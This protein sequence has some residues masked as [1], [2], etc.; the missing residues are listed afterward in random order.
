TLPQF[1]EWLN[2]QAGK[3]PDESQT[4][5]L[6]FQSKISGYLKEQIIYGIEFLLIE[7]LQEQIIPERVAWLLNA[8]GSAWA[9]CHKEFVSALKNDLTIIAKVG[10]LPKSQH[11]EYFNLL[12][13][14]N[15]IWDRLINGWLNVN[16]GGNLTD[17]YPLAKLF[18]ST[19]DYKLAA[20]F[21]QLS[22]ASVPKDVFSKL[23]SDVALN[24]FKGQYLGLNLKS[25]KNTFDKIE[26]FANDNFIPIAIGI[27]LSFTAGILSLVWISFITK[28]HITD[29]KNI[30]LKSQPNPNKDEQIKE[31]EKHIGIKPENFQKT[32]AAILDISSSNTSSTAE[33]SFNKIMQKIGINDNSITYKDFKNGNIRT[34][35]NNTKKVAK[36]IL[37]FQ[38]KIQKRDHKIKRT[39]YLDKGDENTGF[40]KLKNEVKKQQR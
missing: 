35:T 25:K 12:K 27:I 24:K 18:E 33:T 10:S 21:Y 8:K 32:I 40:E 9:S 38:I 23:P 39:A 22:C 36:A 29:N 5:S 13:F 16:R 2:I 19:G 28:N 20:Y 7:L 6:D 17:Y 26:E 31:I 1:L 15:K 37:E 30:P 11:K 3:K 4:V 34:D 14:D